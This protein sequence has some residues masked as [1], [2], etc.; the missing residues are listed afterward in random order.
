[1]EEMLKATSE[2]QER[3]DAAVHRMTRAIAEEGQIIIDSMISKQAE[4]SQPADSFM[5]ETTPAAASSS[6]SEAK[7][8]AQRLSEEVRDEGAEQRMN[9]AHR[10]RRG[11]EA[12]SPSAWEWAQ[13]GNVE[14]VSAMP[15]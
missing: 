12:E 7:L 1:M 8:T 15:G 9:R 2:G 13:F 6:Q 14:E 10:N 4:S 11:A 5:G 3:L